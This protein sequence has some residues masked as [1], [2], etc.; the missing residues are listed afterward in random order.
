M[1]LKLINFSIVDEAKKSQARFLMAWKCWKVL[2]VGFSKAKDLWC[3]NRHFPNISLNRGLL[4]KQ[5]HW[6]R[7]SHPKYQSL[8]DG[9]R[10]LEQMQI[11]TV[12]DEEM[13]QKI[14]I[15]FLGVLISCCPNARFPGTYWKHCIPVSTNTLAVFQLSE[16]WQY[17]KSHCFRAY[18]PFLMFGMAPA[19]HLRH[20]IHNYFWSLLKWKVNQ[21][22]SA[23]SHFE[24]WC[25]NKHSAS[26][27]DNLIKTQS[28]QTSHSVTYVL[29]ET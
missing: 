25:S 6:V 12:K 14:L 16:I 2:E 29:E 18:S 1:F 17:P 23:L 26:Y 7:S 22:L 8:A 19:T 15:C 21:M 4:M 27:H 13:E 28:V 3:H 11:K 24:K 10:L 9:T 20:L 5:S